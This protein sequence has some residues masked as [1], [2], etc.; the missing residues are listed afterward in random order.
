MEALAP[1]F[2]SIQTAQAKG[3]I[4]EGDLDEIF[5]VLGI[6]KL[7]P[8]Y[9]KH[10][11]PELYPRLVRRLSQVIADGLTCPAGRRR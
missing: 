11:A 5:G 9:R 8:H 3:R 2:G 10:I 7:L 1:L 4:V 6:I